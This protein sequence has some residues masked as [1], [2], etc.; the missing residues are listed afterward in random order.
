M[1]T[2][3]TEPSNNGSP[4]YCKATESLVNSILPT[5]DRVE[6]R[7]ALNELSTT[8]SPVTEQ[9]SLVLISKLVR[10]FGLRPKHLKLT[11][12]QFIEIVRGG[13]KVF[14]ESPSG[15]R[16]CVSA[17]GST[18]QITE[19][20]GSSELMDVRWDALKDQLGLR[21]DDKLQCLVVEPPPSIS[22]PE[23][24]DG[25]EP[26]PLRRLWWLLRPEW[27][28]I[29]VVILFA[30]VAGL[31]TLAT[32]IA[33]ETLV[34]TVAFGRVLQPIVILALMLLAFLS[35][36]AAI[37]AVQ[38][39][40]V[41]IVQR[42]L[43][44]RVA[45][46]L[47]YRITKVEMKALDGKNG[48]ELMNRFFDVVTVQK[49][50]SQLLLDGVS[51][52]MGAVIGMAVLAFYHPWLLGF[53]VVLLA[54]IAFVIFVLGRGAVKSSIKESKTKYQ[55]AGWLENL[56]GCQTAFRREES[57][58]FALIRSD[59]IIYGYL[60]ARKAHFRILLRQ[61]MFALGMQAVASTVLLGLGGWLV[62]TGELTLGQL[63]AAELIVTVIV[64][65]FAK[66]GKH[67]ESYY[68]VL[69]SVDKLGVLFD[70][71]LEEHTGEFELEN[72][73][74]HSVTFEN[75]TCVNG[76]G[77]RRL[78]NFH[79]HVDPGERLMITGPSGLG[80]TFII[81][82]LFGLRTANSGSVMIDGI[83]TQ[84]ISLQSLR[85]SVALVR[86]IEI[87]AG[88][89]AENLHLGHVDISTQQM[90][91]G[92]RA[93]GLLDHVMQLP[94]RLDTQLN[95][96]G[97]PLTTNQAKKLMLARAII[98]RPGLLLIDE[99]L[100]GLADQEIIPIIQ[101]LSSPSYPWTLV[102]VTG[103]DSLLEYATQISRFQGPSQTLLN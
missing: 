81:D 46:D 74:R 33:V 92:L 65:S 45:A 25:D 43:F 24:R 62:V 14:W 29:W 83:D 11:R 1:N 94:D 86:D 52:V 91:E 79:C 88:T 3:L 9:D 57:S 40:V 56:M 10:R 75:V 63:V 22:P 66:L 102:M 82:L 47:S 53:D 101:E 48:R 50:C 93:V 51:L 36:S 7:R 27:G 15:W 67:L 64:G 35:F 84:D 60:K 18:Y 76:D 42:R 28:D 49:V 98:A 12:N 26:T 97:A 6:I 4:P 59:R 77:T 5:K 16:A 78:S 39:Y 44:A 55:M 72:Q 70:L 13:G 34:N 103:R 100:D 2:Q 73:Q 87:F 89:I 71:P 61:I 31:L 37:R 38:T 41:E 20:D 32:P 69:A 95:E 80:K 85:R 17:T 90:L 58:E 68:D 19:V 30:V 23:V 21:E 8:H 54:L 99:L 96:F